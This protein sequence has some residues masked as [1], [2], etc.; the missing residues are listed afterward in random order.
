M[1]S[2]SSTL[3]EHLS[4]QSIRLR[5]LRWYFFFKKNA[6]VLCF[7]LCCRTE[8]VR[9]RVLSLYLALPDLKVG[10]LFLLFIIIII[11][12]FLWFFILYLL[13]ASSECS[14]CCER[15]C[16]LPSCTSSPTTASSFGSSL[17]A[18]VVK[19]SCSCSGRSQAS[20]CCARYRNHDFYVANCAH[21]AL[22]DLASCCR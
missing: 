11:I 8:R 5:L 21:C 14:L 18:S 13:F 3:L 19:S 17:Q 7:I 22:F 9:L 15:F 2:R 6:V 10:L 12:I 20:I 4:D 1:P 16:C